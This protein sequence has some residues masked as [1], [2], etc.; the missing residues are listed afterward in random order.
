MTD[1]KWTDNPTE[2][3]VATYNPD[4]LNECLMHLKYDN[5]PK[6][7]TKYCF[8]SGNT[9]SDGN[10]DLVNANLST[11]IEYASPGSYTF[12]APVAGYYKVV[13]VGGGGSSASGLTSLS[14][15]SYAGG[16]SG[17]AFAGEVYL[18]A[19]THTVSV[20]YAGG[21]NNTCLD[22][23]IIAGGGGNAVLTNFNLLA[24][25]QQGGTV[26]VNA[27]VQNI[28][29]NQS[30]N[31]GGFNNGNFVQSGG[32][33][34]Y[35]G[36]GKGADSGC[37]SAATSG[38][39]SI[40]LQAENGN[41]ISYKVGGCYPALTA[42]LATGEQF[43][44]NGLNSDD[45]ELLSDG[46]YIK[47]VGAD[48]SSDLLKN[49]LYRQAATPS[50]VTGDIWYNTSSEPLSVKQW[51]GS[52]W[53]DYYKIP[54]C[55]FTVE[56]CAITDI[57]T[58]AYNQNG[59]DANMK[60]PLAKPSGSYKDLSLPASGGTV[61]APYNGYIQLAALSCESLQI[62]NN[63]RTGY[64]SAIANQ[65]QEAACVSVPCQ[66]G[67]KIQIYYN[68]TTQRWFRCFADEGAI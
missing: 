43:T 21:S 11:N 34:V 12:N 49:T 61:I 32:A 41:C 33:S 42:T 36:Y 38:Y 63:S 4:V 37:G 45:A 19:G 65:A 35:N 46:T 9:D 1:Y 57:V 53:V 44:I 48:G 16:G 29:L 55:K 68:I 50:P 24:T 7:M 40:K 51:N 10:A 20:G 17:A 8:N 6:Q 28:T 14:T 66:K 15:I 67:D 3:D 22:N 5:V 47:Y 39:F 60:S 13:M 25:N 56:N 30:G 64:W 2:A 18:A 59:Y 23:L 54:M 58:F 31:A 26:T 52:A 27:T 62:Y